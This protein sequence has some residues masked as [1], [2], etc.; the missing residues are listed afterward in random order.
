VNENSFP[1]VG[2]TDCHTHVAGNAGTYPMVSPRAYTP[3]VAAPQD[4]RR[5]M[6]R[7]GIEKI[8]I[9]Q[10]SVFGTD[11]RCMLDAMDILGDCTR[12]VVQLDAATDGSA[13][14]ALSAKGVRGIRV[15]LNSTGLNDP[16]I[17]RD[18]LKVAAAQCARNGWHLQLFTTPAVIAELALELQNLPVPVV[19]D[20]F[21]LLSPV[22]RG[23]SAETVVRNLLGKGQAWVK[24]SGTEDIAQLAR[25][26]YKTN[27]ENIV[28][29]SDWPHAP[30]HAGKAE[31]DPAPLP[32]RDLDPRDML[33]T[34]RTWFD[35]ECDRRAVLVDNPARLYDF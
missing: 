35:S 19:L 4:M 15:N 9:V 26:L 5:M 25:D 13:L 27:P 20:H 14:D 28:W 30:H 18:R 31:A 3:A 33:E 12:G 1:P 22:D 23:T 21:G 10:M 32:Y 34:I 16:Q 29:G 8:V 6:D 11:N 7:V 17:A 2:C 24:I